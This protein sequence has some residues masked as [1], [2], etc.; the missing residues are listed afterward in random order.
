[1]EMITLQAPKDQMMNKLQ[2]VQKIQKGRM[3]MQ[4]DLMAY[5]KLVKDQSE[6]PDQQ[7]ITSSSS[8]AEE[9]E[10]DDNRI[11]AEYVKVN[12]TR[13]RFKCEFRNAFILINGK[14]YVTKGINAD[15]GY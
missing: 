1:M 11:Y 12:R 15:F 5:Q 9:E 2:S 8:E 3:S 7:E 14:E 13:T 4:K 6:F 10:E